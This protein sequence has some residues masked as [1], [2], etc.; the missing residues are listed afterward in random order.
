MRILSLT[1]LSCLFPIISL[2]QIVSLSP[3]SVGPDDAVTL[4]F[5][6]TQGNADLEGATKVYLHHGVVTDDPEGTSWKY[7]KGNWGKDDGVGEMT[8]VSGETD[9]WEISFSPS[10]R[11]YFGVPNGEN[12]FRISAVFRTADGSAKA[13]IS[14]GNYGWGTVTSNGDIYIDLNVDNFISIT[15]P[16]QG[17]S[18]VNNGDNVSISAVASSEVSDMKL[19]MNEGS[20]YVEKASV[21]TGT[22]ISYKYKVTETAV[23]DYKITATIDGEEL[24]VTGKHN[25]VVIGP[26]TVK[27]LPAGIELG[28]NYD[29]NDDTKVTLAL[30]APGKDFVFAVGD[31]SDWYALA[32]NQMNVTADGEIFWLELNGLSP[33]KE[34]VFQ[35]WVE[36]DVKIG[37]PYADKVADPWNDASIPQSVYPN[38]P[39]YTKT[40]YL[41][42]TVLQTGQLPYKWAASE[43]IWERPE[44]D[45]LVIYELLVRDF[46]ESHS[47]QD[48]IDTL[49]YI[50]RLGVDA[51][52]LMP[53]N[54][55]EDNESW[56]YN[57]AYH[58][59][60]DK[61]YGTKDDLKA[62]IEAAHAEGLAVILDV[63]LNHAYGLNPLVRMYYN[64][65]TGK[66]TSD[67]PWFNPDHVGP[68]SWGHDFN[69][70]S[71]YT[72][73]YIDRINKYWL[74][75][76]HFD[77]YRFDFTKGF[78]QKG[79]NIDGYDASRIAILKRMADEIWKVDDEAY[80]I[81]E[82]WGSASEENELASYGMQM[83]RNRSYDY[84]PALTGGDGGSF[85]N[86][87]VT[88]HVSYF[89]SHDERRISEH[90]LTEGIS[91]G[92]YNVK[93]PLIMYERSKLAAAFMLLFPG[94]KMMWQFDELGYD[95]H[96]D[97]NGR[98]GNKP[99]PWGSGGLGYY[100]DSLRQHI[101]SVYKG[102]MDVRNTI[103]PEAMASAKTS[104]TL[105]GSLRRLSYDMSGT[106]LVLIGNFGLTTGSISPDFSQTGTWYDYFSGEEISVSNTTE[107]IE[108]AAGEWHVY[109]TTRMSGG[110]PGVV[111]VFK[112]PVIISPVIFTQAEEITIRFDATKAWKNGSNG[113][114][115]AS[116]VYFH[117]GVVID[118][119]IGTKWSNTVGSLTDDG[120]GEMTRVSGETDI[121]EITLTPE[122]YY[123]L[124]GDEAFKMGM[125]FRDADNNNFGYGFRDSE[126]YFD[127]DSD[128]PFIT[129][130]PAA[131]RAWDEITITFNARKGNK[132]L[133]GADKVYMHSG[134]GTKATQQPWNTSWNNTVGNWGED[135]GIG[136]M[137]KVPG[138]PDMWQITLTPREYYGLK[139]GD[140]AFWL[141]AVFRSA[142]GNIKG[143]GTPGEIENGIIHSNQD[144]FIR[145]LWDVSTGESLQEAIQ[146]YPNPVADQLNI[147][148]GQKQVSQV[149]IINMTGEV[150]YSL[151]NASQQQV[152]VLSVGPL[153]T[154][155]YL[156]RLTGNSGVLTRELVKY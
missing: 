106:D 12:I 44:P 144:Y 113:L 140:H 19:F 45:H 61:Y 60:A 107:R 43:N 14:P 76:F 110:M 141:A 114:V 63:V 31:F 52:E 35:Y 93:D 27:A 128:Q 9:K 119:P 83:W 95:I 50:K 132:E 97:Y 67:N 74:E 4:T 109:T 78:T 101:Y 80:V 77:G 87:D 1:I 22:T 121:W 124:G 89:N 154:G 32:K 38:L 5:D 37:D 90:M 116:K 62:F 82:H 47:Y 147:Y 39:E 145:N 115:G 125:Y 46:L 11:D 3:T 28:I 86:M 18:F 29:E 64:E 134:M 33:Q 57:P 88:S 108:L 137:S 49:S 65:S 150:V 55:F 122:D 25:A 24:E 84:V 36:E 26:S 149:E 70:E 91:D 96:I 41:T 75:E 99:L 72:K 17:N 142:D 71:Q 79:P 117:S 10:I 30:Q 131:F 102:L 20:G 42:A 112:N 7:V 129:I 139:D 123:S 111:E 34:Y 153:Q 13:T 152:M 104:H 69:H 85:S 15:A 81:L 94:P 156:I 127:I 105:I 6:A 98:V 143:T 68:F 148:L 8:K 133:V 23:L 103:T 2:A 135:D 120:V 54:E 66:T 130:E 40:E 126:I 118:D 48:L 53:I 92:G 21:S 51:I 146:I 100:E 56:G 58:M 155:V 151:A 59:A 136:K 73:D 16:T 138:Q